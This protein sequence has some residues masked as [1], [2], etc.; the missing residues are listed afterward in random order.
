MNM[1]IVSGASMEPTLKGGTPYKWF[2]P[3]DIVWLSRVKRHNPKRGDVVVYPKPYDHR[4]SVIKRVIA[5]PGDVIVT[6]GNYVCA[7]FLCL[8]CLYDLVLTEKL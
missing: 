5:L 4:A 7:L 1:I 8:L 6:N 2:S 3:G